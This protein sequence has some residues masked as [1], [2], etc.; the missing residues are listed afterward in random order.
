MLLV[1]SIY[2][3]LGKK[4]EEALRSRS[5]GREGR[6][7]R[8]RDAKEDEGDKAARITQEAELSSPCTSNSCCEIFEI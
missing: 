6:G 2:Q 4:L 8:T 5:R 7:R 1:M 3:F